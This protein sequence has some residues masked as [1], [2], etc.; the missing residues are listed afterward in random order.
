MY[1]CSC[2]G[3]THDLKAT[4]LLVVAIQEDGCGSA[5]LLQMCACFMTNFGQ[6]V[7]PG[8]FQVSSHVG[9]ISIPIIGF[10]PC[11]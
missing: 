2:Q 6:F 10:S 11:K 3:N 8:V 7:P 4:L 5:C 1:T 9:L